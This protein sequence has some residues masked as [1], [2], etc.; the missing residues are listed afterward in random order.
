MSL[1]FGITPRLQFYTTTYGNETS[2]NNATTTT[3]AASRALTTSVFWTGKIGTSIFLHKNVGLDVTFNV[4]TAD[5]SVG[6][7]AQMSIAL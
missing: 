1:F 7:S 6:L 4:N 5:K 3:A 2:T